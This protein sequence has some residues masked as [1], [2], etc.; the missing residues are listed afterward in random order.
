MANLVDILFFF[1]SV[2]QGF[3]YL[4]KYLSWW[5]LCDIGSRQCSKR[6]TG[7]L[8]SLSLLCKLQKNCIFHSTCVIFLCSYSKKQVTIGSTRIHWWWEFHQRINQAIL[9][10]NTSVA[11]WCTS[12]FMPACCVLTSQFCQNGGWH[13]LQSLFV[14]N[15]KSNFLFVLWIAHFVRVNWFLNDGSSICDM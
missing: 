1:K 9:T 7:N 2:H 6:Q 13:S 5:P 3:S 12:C 4:W 11:S 14:I 8:T 10:D 15:K